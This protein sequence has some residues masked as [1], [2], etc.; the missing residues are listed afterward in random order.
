MRFLIFS[1]D[2]ADSLPVRKSNRDAH[3]AFLITDKAAEVLMAGPW[4]DE[5]GVMVGSL[6]VVDCVDRETLDGWIARDPYA[7]AGLVGEATVKP[8]MWAIGAPD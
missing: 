1:K 6:L 3:L 5:D 7:A 4:L 8:F 2:K